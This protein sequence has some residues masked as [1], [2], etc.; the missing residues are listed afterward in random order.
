MNDPLP[1][2]PEDPRWRPAPYYPAFDP[3]RQELERIGRE[4]EESDRAAAA[5]RQLAEEER[6]IAAQKARSGSA[7]RRV[8]Q[9]PVPGQKAGRRPLGPIEIAALRAMAGRSVPMERTA[10]W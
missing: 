2:Y 10:R 5:R 4:I 6:W 9:G 1:N 8:A 7:A 3:R